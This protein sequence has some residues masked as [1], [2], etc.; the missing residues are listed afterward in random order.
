MGWR[1]G[2]C[3]SLASK[4]SDW[5]PASSP[6]PKFKGAFGTPDP[7]V[8]LAGPRSFLGDFAI[9]PLTDPIVEHFARMRASLRQ[10]GHLI[11]DMEFFISAT[12]LEHDLALITRNVRHFERI[13]DLQLYQPS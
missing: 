3:Y 2:G 5:P 4:P 13:S 12:A 11:P 6:L 1:S 7:H 10:H 8:T 9:L